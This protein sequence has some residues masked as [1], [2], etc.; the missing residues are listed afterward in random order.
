MDLLVS[1]QPVINNTDDTAKD[2]ALW[3]I[4]FFSF[5]HAKVVMELCSKQS[6]LLLL[7]K[8]DLFL[9]AYGD[10]FISILIVPKAGSPKAVIFC[11]LR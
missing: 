3:K 7:L 1:Q 4:R 5:L 2:S 11:T 8:S 10:Q 6:Q 9:N